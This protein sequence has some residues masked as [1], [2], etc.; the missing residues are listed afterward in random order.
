MKAKRYALFF[1]FVFSIFL[2]A[3][4]IIKIIEKGADVSYFFDVSEEEKKSNSEENSDTFIFTLNNDY[5]YSYFSQKESNYY[6]LK[7]NFY[8]SIVLD[9]NCPPPEFILS[10]TS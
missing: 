6:F 8:P 5:S 4:S 7:N 2:I 10:F 1:L 3:P 9:Q